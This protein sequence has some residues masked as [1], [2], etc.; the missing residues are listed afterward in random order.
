M[1]MLVGAL[2]LALTVTAWWLLS[3]REQ[4][5][6]SARFQLQSEERFRAIEARLTETL[7]AVY[8]P[9]AFYGAAATIQPDEL[10]ALVRT[11]SERYSGIHALLWAPRSIDGGREAVKVAM[12]EPGPEAGALLGLDLKTVPTVSSVFEALRARHGPIASGRL[13]L[14]GLATDKAEIL[15]MAPV[16][17][18]GSHSRSGDDIEKPEGYVAAVVRIDAVIEEGLKVLGS[19]RHQCV[20]A[21]E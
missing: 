2:S 10:R 15:I 18:T 12:A 6:L 14:P 8:V 9:Q 3:K 16:S 11:L 13:S 17:R 1:P 5:L 7:G 19:C 4:E 21:S 20:L